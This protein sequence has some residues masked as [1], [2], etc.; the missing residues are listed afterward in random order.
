M[1]STSRSLRAL[2]LLCTLFVAAAYPQRD[3]SR[4]DFYAR[5]PYRDAVPRPQ[6]IL[7]YDVGEFH[8]NY[9]MMERVLEKIAQ[10]AP[11]RVRVMDMGETNEHRM[12]HLVAVS[13][14][15]NIQRLS[16]IKADIARLADPRRTS[17]EEARRITSSSPMI[18]W[19]A[20]TIHGNESASFEAM[21]Q[22]LYQL[23]AS[24]EPADARHPA[25]LR[26]PHQRLREPG[27]A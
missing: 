6:S 3:D 20:Y 7:R 9:A 17:A 22:V 14:P 21:M 10:A 24:N 2:A 11:D 25:Q 27:R 15:E 13:A 8:T 19:L 4:F 18:V 1:I 12:M 16:E 5:G 26:R 23:A